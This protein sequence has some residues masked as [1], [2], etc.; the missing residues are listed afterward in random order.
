MSERTLS[1]MAGFAGAIQKNAQR[2]VGHELPFFTVAGE[3][4]ALRKN[5]SSGQPYRGS[6]CF[7]NRADNEATTFVHPFYNEVPTLEFNKVV[8]ARNYLETLRQELAHLVPLVF[9]EL[10]SVHTRLYVSV[11][12]R[13]R[14]DLDESTEHFAKLRRNA[15]LP[16]R[17]VYPS[18][19]RL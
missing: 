17:V 5:E 8:I 16:V 15:G 3:V 19:V 18:P 7:L 2:L 9:S 11:P 6:L 4:R 1:T 12:E 10:D 14:I 13:K